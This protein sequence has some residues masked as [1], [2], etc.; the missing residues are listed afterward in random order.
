MTGAQGCVFVHA[1]LL[2]GDVSFWPSRKAINDHFPQQQHRPPRLWSYR[3]QVIGP[4]AEVFDP[5]HGMVVF[6]R[7][8]KRVKLHFLSAAE[9]PDFQRSFQMNDR[10]QRRPTTRAQREFIFRAPLRPV[11]EKQTDKSA[12][13]KRKKHACGPRILLAS[14]ADFLT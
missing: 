1:L 14:A 6:S 8:V 5:D 13:A 7:I 3:G 2:P 9:L 12:A 4:I 11:T 10:L